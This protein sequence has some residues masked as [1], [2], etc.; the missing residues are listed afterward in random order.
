MDSDA[1]SVHLSV[2][3]SITVTRPETLPAFNENVWIK[4]TISNLVIWCI[5]LE[6]S[7]PSSCLTSLAKGY[8]KSKKLGESITDLVKYADWFA[9]LNYYGQFRK[10]LIKELHA[11]KLEEVLFLIKK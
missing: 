3:P 4:I 1:L 10:V 2:S 6:I 9:R 7:M 8:K 5:Y 11:I